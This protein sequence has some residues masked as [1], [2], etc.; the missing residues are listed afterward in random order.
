MKKIIFT[1]TA[2]ALLV[3]AFTSCGKKAAK[4]ADEGSDEILYAVTAKKLSV[5]TL[6]DYLEFGG[7]VDSVSSVSVLPDMAG[8]LSAVKVSVGDNVVKNQ[9]I[10][11]VDASRPGYNYS[12]SPVKAPAAGRIISLVTNIGTTVS[13]A[14][15]VAKISNTEEMEIKI[16][17]P[18]RF[19]SRV[20][21]G[22]RVELTFDAYP[23]EV[24]GAKVSEVSP[25][26]DNSSRTMLTK[27]RIVQR[28]NQIK[29][30]MYA[31][32]KLITETRSNSIVL[33]STAIVTREGKPYV[34]VLN[35]AASED[36]KPTVHQQAVKLGLTIDDK[37]EIV[38]GLTA[39]QIVVTKGQ[40][41]L[42]EGS[43]VNVVS[44]TE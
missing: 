38:D 19:I 25:V 30:G 20:K 18:E 11:Y 7:D 22:Q 9:I 27:V 16:N 36:E 5:G 33:S 6:D 15:P 41:L 29:I 28:N 40:S 12:E 8:K 13:Q 39:G 23:G 1:L 3:T 34:F 17:V 37:T 21:E 44:L 31:R 2:A 35:Q 14:M 24:F 10:A 26:L 43:K 4:A 32:V 42:S